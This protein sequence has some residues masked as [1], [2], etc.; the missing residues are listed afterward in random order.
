MNTAF[1]VIRKGAVLANGVGMSNFLKLFIFY[2]HILR[3]KYL[4]NDMTC[5]ESD[6]K[7]YWANDEF[8]VI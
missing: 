8:K 2:F 5:L 3:Y 1:L 4:Q 6:I 7:N